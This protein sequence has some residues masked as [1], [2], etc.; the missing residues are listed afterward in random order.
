MILC[1]AEPWQNNTVAAERATTRWMSH[2]LHSSLC[3]YIQQALGTEHWMMIAMAFIIFLFRPEDERGDKWWMSHRQFF[4]SR[5]FI[6]L[7]FCSRVFHYIA[8]SSPI[9]GYHNLSIL[10]KQSESAACDGGNKTEGQQKQ[11]KLH[12]KK[13]TQFHWIW[14]SN[15]VHK[16]CMSMSWSLQELMTISTMARKRKR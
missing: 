2:R 15:A 13:R 9:G 1:I 3:C 8:K 14:H 11:A 10:A 7:I 4:S 6:W 12:H 5:S 16:P